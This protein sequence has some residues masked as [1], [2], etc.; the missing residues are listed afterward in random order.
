M[1]LLVAYILVPFVSALL[2]SIWVFPKVLK[3]ALDKNIVDNP[4]AR[5]LQRVPVPVMGGVAVFFGIIIGICSSQM[6]FD[7]PKVFM[8]IMAML[9][10]LYVGT[11]D[12]VIDLTPT[13]RFIIEIIIIMRVND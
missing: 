13:I 9:I 5:K 6:M 2:A 7:E 1:F 10:M 8:L 11:M 12:D 4:D 3:I